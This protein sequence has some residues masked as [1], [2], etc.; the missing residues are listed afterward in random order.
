M[1][2]TKS[3]ITTGDLAAADE[4]EARRRSRRFAFWSASAVLLAAAIFASFTVSLDYVRYAP[5]TAYVTEDQITVD[6]T[7]VFDPEGQIRFLTVRVRSD[8]NVWD[9]LSTWLDD[10][11]EL[12][13]KQQVTGGRSRDEVR[14]F[15][16]LLMDQ[17]LVTAQRVALQ[18]LNIP[19]TGTGVIVR[20]VIEGA[21]ASEKLDGGDRI[22]EIDGEP[23]QFTDDLVRIV[24]A[25][26]PGE[27]VTVGYVPAHVDDGAKELAKIE[28]TVDE[29]GPQPR[30]VLGVFTADG[31]P[32]PG[33]A[34]E[35]D[36]N[37]VGGPS[38]GLAWTLS[39]IDIL[40]PGELT[41]GA[42]IAVTGTIGLDGQVGLVDG[43][44]QKAFA[45]RDAGA[46]LFL[47]PMIDDDELAKVREAAGAGMP[48][49]RVRN[50]EEALGVLDQF[51]AQ[52]GELAAG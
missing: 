32:D 36:R 49:V 18:H 21:P 11:Y 15:N 51:A 7:E 29:S 14:Q 40:T 38:A 24:S 28:L 45:A 33:F 43:V 27:V 26:A 46:T 16:V 10:R 39:L 19:F 41:G 4:A 13:D 22:V 9:A 42:T 6:G 34:V 47:V 35:I 52:P 1:D 2:T 44:R 8:V 12:K 50:L 23:V 25:R 30:T 3:M 5:G 31:A 17:S 48:V 20:A 37:D